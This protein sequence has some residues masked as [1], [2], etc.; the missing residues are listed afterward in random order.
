AQLLPGDSRRTGLPRRSLTSAQR[1]LAELLFENFARH[2]LDRAWL[3][4]AELERT[5]GRAD[6]TVHLQSQRI[7]HAPH[8]AVLALGERHRDPGVGAAAAL[9]LG[10]DWPI[11]H[12]IDGDAVLQLVE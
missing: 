3:E 1:V 10:L 4:R 12:A 6:Q 7:E 9:E 5:V 2:F 8:F 11:A